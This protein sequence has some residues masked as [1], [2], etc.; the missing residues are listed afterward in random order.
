MDFKKYFYYTFAFLLFCGCP[1][2]PR[3][4]YP[5]EEAE[6]YYT[7]NH[8]RLISVEPFEEA[9]KILLPDAITN[10][11]KKLTDRLPQWHTTGK[12]K[13]PLK[14][15][16]DFF[17]SQIQPNIL[18]KL[19]RKQY[20]TTILEN[21]YKAFRELFKAA[22]E[23]NEKKLIEEAKKVQAD[24]KLIDGWKT[25]IKE[26]YNSPETIYLTK[27]TL[28]YQ[29]FLCFILEKPNP[30][31]AQLSNLQA[32]LKT[33]KIEARPTGQA[34]WIK[35]QNDYKSLLEGS[36][37][38]RYEAN[39]KAIEESLRIIDQLTDDPHSLSYKD[40]LET[41]P[42]G[43]DQYS[44]ILVEIGV[45]EDKLKLYLDLVLNSGIKFARIS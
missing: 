10:L 29:A 27:P 6:G 25:C 1:N 22:T 41:L 24:T 12:E 13:S 39:R 31:I 37:F 43:I 32:D 28:D 26:S 8:Y 21:Y 5:N 4:Q 23:E 14:L 36:K 44:N 19:K 9:I 11:R 2:S 45:K 16:N 17:T 35:M 42:H 38:Y 3:E 40:L 33:W 30:L 15:W 34:L 7:K 18:E 20:N